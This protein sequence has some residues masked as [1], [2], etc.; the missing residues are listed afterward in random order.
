MME[1]KE[2]NLT[3]W[4]RLSQTMGPN[5]LLGQD[6]PTYKFD[7]K[8]LLRTTDKEEYEKEKLQARQSYYL[9]QQWAK[10][11]NNLYSQAVYYEPT[12]LS[13]YYDYESME[14]CIHGDTKIAT[15]D[16]FITIKEL[17]DKGSDFEFITYSYD[18]NLKR[19]VPAKARNAHY[20]RD[21]MTYKVT[22]DDGSFIITTWEHQLMKRD[23][24][25]ERV[26]NLQ[27]GDSM[28]PFYRKSFYNNKK[29]NW[30]YTCN[31]NEGHNGWV[32]E[33]NLIAKWFYDTSI[34][35][36]EEVHHIDF[37]G[38]NNQP[39]NLQIMKIS[40]HRSYHAKLNN[41][42][43]WSNPDFRKKMSEVAKRKGKMSWDGK[44]SGNNNPSY[45]PIGFDNI[46][47]TAR[48]EKTL[49]KTAIKLNVSYRKVQREIVNSGYCDWQTFLDAYGIEKSK[50]STAKTKGDVINL[51]HKIESIEPYGVIPVYDLTVPGYKN[52]A[53]DTIF[54]HNT[55]EIS[56]ALDTYAEESTTVDE[57]GYMLQIYSDSTRVKSILGDLFNN[58]LDINTNLPMWTRNAAKY[59]DNF[60]FLKLDPEKGVV[61]C[62]QLPNIE[63]ERVEVGMRGKATSG[64]AMAGTGDQAQSLTFTWKNKQLEFNSWEIAHFRLLGDDRKLPYGTSMLEKARRIW[65][66]LILGEDAML[67]YRVSRAPERR[68]F[69]VYV[70][71]MDDGDIQPYVQRF[72]AQFKKDMITDSSTGNVDMRFNQMAVDQ[73][74]F[75]PVRDPSAPNPIETLQGAQNLSEIADIEY[76]QKKLLTALRI[77]KAFLGFEEVVGDG[78][79]LSLQDIRFART[80]NRI[81]KSMIAE[82]NKIAIIHLFLLGFEDELG[83]FQLS[84]TNPS[85]QA[86][87][88]TIDVWKEKMLLYKDAV[89]PIEG[90]APVSQSWA[91]KH[92]LGFSDEEIKLDLQQQR[93]EKAVATEIQNTA[94]VITRTG[95]FDTVDK[96]YGNGAKTVTGETET[97]DT[98]FDA[99]GLGT[100]EAPIPAEVGGE[101]TPES[102]E[103]RINVITE[104]DDFTTI[105]EID[106]EKGKRFLGE[107]E[108]ELRKIMD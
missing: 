72:A 23:G 63:V 102:L 62:L 89:M 70:G 98:E 105:S 50:F 76:I 90:I 108:N 99:G 14:Y 33:H 66:Q 56:A 7:K 100:D 54:S 12:R 40:E 9:T 69:K 46:I 49:K 32:S 36:D 31:S 65:K 75:I 45:F 20:T 101:V 34:E 83:S 28:M 106:L 61:G 19:V 44:R 95:I 52:F 97:T 4:Q 47:E 85:K 94:N 8:E 87:L 51:N 42:K 92:I 53:T 82:L 80:I 59:G 13:S 24:S 25:F 48:G 17:A 5:S 81:Q 55:P 38:K 6:L 37:N 10:I 91:K 27:K 77:P 39:K 64:A 79:S 60:V 26:M 67:V 103:K 107:I 88:L 86:D 15:P 29:Y 30:I 68:V 78:R 93:V 21:E 84:L 1:D 43:L 2:K 18:H 73:D 3:I 41:E 57:N 96:L 74:F 35:K 104:R 16:G 22:F 58:A 71:N 11:E